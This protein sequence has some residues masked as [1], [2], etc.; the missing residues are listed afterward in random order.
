MKMRNWKSIVRTLMAVVVTLL[1][2]GPVISGENP[3]VWEVSSGETL[4]LKLRSG[5]SVEVEAWDE[6]RVEIAYRDKIAAL[7]DWNIEIS[8]G[9]NGLLVEAKLGGHSDVNSL[10]F[11]IKVPREFNIDLDSGGGELKVTGV[12]G[13]FSGKTAGGGITL[14]DVE[15]RARLTSGGGPIEVT[16]S[17]LD[18]YIRTGGGTVL[19]ED[20]VGDLEATSGGGETRYNNVRDLDGELRAPGR[21]S[22]EGLSQDALLVFSAGGSLRFGQAPY[23]ASLV[24]GG[25]EIE[26]LNAREFV[27]ATTGGGDIQIRVDGGWVKA[28]TGAGDIDV[29]FEGQG[30]D[31]NETVLVTGYGNVTLTV[32]AG[33]SMQLNTDLR[34]TRNS[35][36]SFQVISDLDITREETTDWDTSHGSPVRHIY[37]TATLAGGDHSVTIR[38]TNGD[39]RIKEQ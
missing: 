1:C 33:F 23:G 3:V 25:G 11:A 20:V 15:G 29:V 30:S 26:V 27:S 7:D 6:D 34:Y 10:R 22:T 39:I 17:R 9:E 18:G 24:T 2:S 14:R 5:G 13:K 31:D 21:M 19:V 38:T 35:S 37:G 8:R 28:N 12:R 36:R 4:E 16:D 32:P